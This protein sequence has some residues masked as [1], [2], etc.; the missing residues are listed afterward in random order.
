ATVVHTMVTWGIGAIVTAVRYAIVV[1]IGRS[2][3]RRCSS[4]SLGHRGCRAGAAKAEDQRSVDTVVMVV[5]VHAPE[6]S[7]RS[8]Q[9]ESVVDLV[10][11]P[12]ARVPSGFFV[13]VEIV[14]TNTAHD[15]RSQGA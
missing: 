2:C 14:M 6:F 4:R 8:T 11:N 15:E 12:Q 7:D 13:N 1:R 5:L 9:F 10:T 3:R